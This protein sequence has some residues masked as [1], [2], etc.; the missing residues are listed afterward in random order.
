MVKY[1]DI[2]E[3]KKD[4]RK[5]FTCVV[6]IRIP[7]FYRDFLIQR[8]ISIKKL[9]MAVCEEIEPTLKNY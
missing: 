9:I 8:K 6:A 3:N 7:I 2:I 5:F 4:D 1:E